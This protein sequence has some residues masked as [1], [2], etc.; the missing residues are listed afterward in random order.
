MNIKKLK[1]VAL[2]ILAI[3]SV[4]FVNATTYE[5][6]FYEET[7]KIKPNGKLGQIVKKQE[8]KTSLK[9]AKAFKIAYI[10][11]DVNDKKTITTGLMVV[12]TG[13]VP[14]GGRGVISWSHGTTG[15]A[16][17]CGP[18][19]V[20]N[21]ASEL[22][23]YFLM[24]GDSWTDYGIPQ[25]QVFLDEGHVLVSTDFQGLGGGGKHQYSVAITNARDTI[26]IMR[27]AASIKE[28]RIGSKAVI[29][30]WSQGGGAAFAAVNDQEYLNRKGTS[31]DNLKLIGSV[32]LAPDDIAA[33]MPKGDITEELAN[34]FMADWLQ[35]FSDNPANFAHM[36]MNLWGTQAAFP[37][38]L[39]LTDV[40]T[41]EGAKNLD[42]LMSNKC[43]H[44]MTDTMNF[45]FGTTYKDFLRKDPVNTKAWTMAML[46]GSGQPVKS[47]IPIVIYW[48][49][50]DVVVPPVMHEI[51][52]KQMCALGS[53]VT[54]VQLKGEQSHFTTP[55]TSAV[56]Y[57]KWINDR[58][59][60][61]PVENS[62]ENI[63][64]Q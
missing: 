57:T 27:A 50:K 59:A 29:Y 23:E 51:Y 14:E 16:Q 26:D 43:I 19:Q 9:N 52:Q 54:R 41:E 17:N 20:Q 37:D 28:N 47:D 12:P 42:T 31:Y 64:Q 18:S 61:K 49:T 24:N 40:F 60:G 62:C 34:K 21:P 3:G 13:K 45:N 56:S 30:G 35:K 7:M 25:A 5:S 15:T 39:K 33:L 38:K 48:G 10:S 53:S 36:T 2:S 8:I 32:G 58:F 55:S 11:S 1:I 46:K 4:S 22:K 6:N 63:L 44:A